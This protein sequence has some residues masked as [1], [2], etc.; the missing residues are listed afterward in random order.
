MAEPQKITNVNL[1]SASLGPVSDPQVVV[2]FVKEK[3]RSDDPMEE[4]IY[5]CHYKD[6]ELVVW[7]DEREEHADT[8]NATMITSDNNSW[9]AE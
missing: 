2:H 3:P 6:C 8:H 4:P 1:R 5:V 9:K 7:G